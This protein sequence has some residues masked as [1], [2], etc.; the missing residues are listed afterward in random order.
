MKDC[1]DSITARWRHSSP[2]PGP[3]NFDRQQ[4]GDRDNHVD[5]WCG[6]PEAIKTSHAHAQNRRHSAAGSHVRSL[7][8]SDLTGGAVVV[9][10]WSGL[11]S[12][13]DAV[14]AERRRECHGCPGRCNAFVEGVGVGVGV[15]RWSMKS[16]YM[17][18]CPDHFVE[19]AN[20]CHAWCIGVT[21]G[22]AHTVVARHGSGSTIHVQSPS[23][24]THTAGGIERHT[25]ASVSKSAQAQ[26]EPSG[27]QFIIQY[28]QVLS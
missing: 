4:T 2:A 15:S 24:A 1:C 12:C 26:S 8:C 3:Y 13:C 10:S 23:R 18:C 14:V 19:A 11:R 20:L 9:G 16:V 25:S 6:L 27:G 21:G 17:A 22:I 28:Q 7:V 5:D